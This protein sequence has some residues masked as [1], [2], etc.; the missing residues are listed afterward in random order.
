MAF[1]KMPEGERHRLK[2][3]LGNT[4]IRLRMNPYTSANVRR[5][6]I[7]KVLG[8]LLNVDAS[9]EGE[10]SLPTDLKA[11]VGVEIVRGNFDGPRFTAI[12]GGHFNPI[13][14][15][16]LERKFQKQYQTSAPKELL[17]Y[18]ET[19]SAPPEEEIVRLLGIVSQL[20]SAATF[21]KVWI[22]DAVHKTVFVTK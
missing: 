2:E 7:N 5:S 21:E 18:F 14:T 1:S 22:F 17:I 13:P 16:A 19:Q 9:F 3:Q 12:A 20:N 8:E 6:I 15:E 11:I 10:Y 4:T